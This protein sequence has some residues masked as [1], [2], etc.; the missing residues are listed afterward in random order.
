MFVSCMLIGKDA[1]GGYG[2]HRE[3]LVRITE[4][5]KVCRK[6]GYSQIHGGNDDAHPY[7]NHK[8]ETREETAFI[9]GSVDFDYE[10]I[11]N[12]VKDFVEQTKQR[13]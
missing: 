10:R 7:T 4:V 12:D 6:C 11:V 13:Q 1:E 2:W 8:W 5:D 9:E 3:I